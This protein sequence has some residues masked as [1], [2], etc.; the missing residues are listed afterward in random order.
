MDTGCK[1][2][3]PEQAIPTQ[4]NSV[5]ADLDYFLRSSTTRPD[6]VR[7]LQTFLRASPRRQEPTSCIGD[8]EV[9]I[10]LL[11]DIQRDFEKYNVWSWNQDRHYVTAALWASFMVA[12]LD[13]VRLIRDKLHAS[14]LVLD[15]IELLSVRLPV[16]MKTFLNKTLSR[17]EALQAGLPPQTRK[18]KMQ[19]TEVQEAI[20]AT[21]SQPEKAKVTN[22]D[23]CC[24]ITGTA[25]PDICYVFPYAARKTLKQTDLSLKILRSLW[26]TD[27]HQRMLRLLAVDGNIIDTAQNM[28]AMSPQLHRLW[29]MAKFGLEPT[30]KLEYGIR[31]RFRWLHRTGLAMEHLVPLDLDPRKVFET[32]SDGSTVAHNSKTFRPILDGEIIDIT[33]KPTNLTFDE[34]AVP[35]WDIFSLQWDLVRMASLCGAPEVVDE[36]DSSDWDDDETS[37]D[38]DEMSEDDAYT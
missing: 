13:G 3:S 36:D 1:G 21:R 30:E 12:P 32:G 29:S 15:T 24:V 23:G 19:P 18:R 26:G 5:L 2:K 35:S 20:E 14:V 31:V 11:R 16:T 6:D 4:K 7:A 9:R 27:A 10:Q 28:V 33:A 22:R 8:L 38:D 34:S 25:D 17:T 37:E